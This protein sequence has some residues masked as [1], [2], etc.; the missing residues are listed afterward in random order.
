[1]SHKRISV[2]DHVDDPSLLVVELYSSHLLHFNEPIDDAVIRRD[3]SA[4]SAINEVA[5]L[6]HRNKRK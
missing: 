1:M 5:L 2:R 3:Q 6:L 4:Q